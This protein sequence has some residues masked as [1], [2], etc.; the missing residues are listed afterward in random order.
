MCDQLA[1]EWTQSCPFADGFE[2]I[3]PASALGAAAPAGCDLVRFSEMR[4]ARF[5]REFERASTAE[6][7]RHDPRTTTV[8]VNDISEGPDFRAV[9]EA[10]FRVFTIYHVDVVAYVADIYARG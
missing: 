7:P 4:Y 8:L 5:R 6:I 1:R 10:G 9:A 3:S 2:L